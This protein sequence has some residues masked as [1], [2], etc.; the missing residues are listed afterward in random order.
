MLNRSTIK[1]N[2]RM[3][4]FLLSFESRRKINEIN[5]VKKQTEKKKYLRITKKNYDGKEEEAPKKKIIKLASMK[6]FNCLVAA[7]DRMNHLFSPRRLY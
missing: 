2:T 7:N 6:S 5:R 3:V 1:L 4:V